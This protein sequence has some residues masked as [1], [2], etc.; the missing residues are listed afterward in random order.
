MRG[1]T[2]IRGGSSCG[3]SRSRPVG[4]GSAVPLALLLAGVYT[5]KTNGREIQGLLEGEHRVRFELPVRDEEEGGGR[6]PGEEGGRP[7]GPR[8][9]PLIDP[10]Y[11][12]FGTSGLKVTVSAPENRVTLQLGKP[13]R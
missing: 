4:N 11:R 13:G 3:A 7:G 5:Y 9:P 8:K 6:D 2:P 12:A 10:R 1:T